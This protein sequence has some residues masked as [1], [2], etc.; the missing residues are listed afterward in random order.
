M[1]LIRTVSQPLDFKTVGFRV[2]MVCVVVLLLALSSAVISTA[3]IAGAGLLALGL[4]AGTGALI[5]SALPWLMQK[6][7][8]QLLA[9]RKAEARKNPVEQLQ[10]DCLRRAERLNTF[11]QAL[12]NIGGQIESMR[13]MLEER[14]RVNPGQSLERQQRALERM[15]F[16]YEVHIG[17]LREANVALTA[18]Q[19]LVKHKEFEWRFATLAGDIMRALNPREAEELLQNILSDEALKEVQQRFNAVYAE[20]DI[21]MR[22]PDSPAHAHLNQSALDPLGDLQIELPRNTGGRP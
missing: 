16:F 2:A 22:A 18:F 15:G 9:L 4:L 14:R 8:N 7:E 17:R 6:V 11:R 21:G 1:D 10:N 20:L 13:D 19:D 3:V 12:V 5:F